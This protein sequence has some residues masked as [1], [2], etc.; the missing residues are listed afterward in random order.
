MLRVTPVQPIGAVSPYSRSPYQ[1]RRDHRPE[2]QADFAQ[3]LNEAVGAEKEGHMELTET[4]KRFDA[5]VAERRAQGRKTYGTGLEHT[6]DY[7]WTLMA[8]EEAL[9]LSQYLMARIVEM[10]DAIRDGGR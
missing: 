1:E 3:E 9:D 6:A 4:E 2:S 7:S 8:L 10:E 5:L